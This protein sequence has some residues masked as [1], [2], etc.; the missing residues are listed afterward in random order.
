MSLYANVKSLREKPE[1]S[2]VG[3]KWTSKE[4]DKLM[5]RVKEG[6]EIDDI[7][8]KHSRTSGS[9]RSRILQKSCD[10]IRDDNMSIEDV[11]RLVR[12]T[13]DDIEDFKKRQEL[14]KHIQ[15]IKNEEIS[16]D[17]IESTEETDKYMNILVEIRDLLKMIAAK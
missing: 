10:M 13:V 4:D 16:S 3:M 9:I 7:A 14:K 2:R 8:L 12:M 11:S 5:Q 15:D 17:S 1:T 6:M